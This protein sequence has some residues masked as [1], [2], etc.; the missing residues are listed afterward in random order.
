MWTKTRGYQ[1]VGP[2]FPVTLSVFR[3]L[4]RSLYPERGSLSRLRPLVSQKR[5]NTRP[6][7]SAF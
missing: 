2:H 3:V 1:F 5:P 7:D 6:G 4:G